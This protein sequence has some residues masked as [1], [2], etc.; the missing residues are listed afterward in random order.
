MKQNI[1]DKLGLKTLHKMLQ[2]FSSEYDHF[3]TV[4]IHS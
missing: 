3:V 4:D 2:D 1:P